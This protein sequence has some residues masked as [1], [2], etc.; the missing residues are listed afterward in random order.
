MSAPDTATALAALHK[1]IG[2]LE[3]D[4]SLE[5]GGMYLTRDKA[6]FYLGADSGAARRLAA[7]EAAFEGIAG[8]Y[9]SGAEVGTERWLSEGSVDGLPLD[10]RANLYAV[11]E[12]KIT[13]TTVTEVIGWV[14]KPAVPESGERA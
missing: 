2:I 11:A 10:I 9:T 3:A 13:G 8:P 14:R 12:R 4:L 1:V 5:F 7:M 6:E